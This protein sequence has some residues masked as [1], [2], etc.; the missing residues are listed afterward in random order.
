MV[1]IRSV[2]KTGGQGEV[3]ATSATSAKW[4]EQLAQCSMAQLVGRSDILTLIS[5]QWG[6]MPG[7][8]RAGFQCLGQVPSV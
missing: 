2:N 3:A 1:T 5:G 7:V 4:G 8:F 6:E